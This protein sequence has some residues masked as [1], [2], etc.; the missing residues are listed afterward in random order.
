MGQL[1]WRFDDL[2]Y[3]S[4]PTYLPDALQVGWRVR[5]VAHDDARFIGA[6][7]VIRELTSRWA[8]NVSVRLD[9]NISLGSTSARWIRTG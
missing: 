6:E 8:G 4:S 9:S 5:C 1:Q 3:E 2:D 7:G